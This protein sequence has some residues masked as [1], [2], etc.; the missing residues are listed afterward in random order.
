[1]AFKTFGLLLLQKLAT[2]G[3]APDTR[4]SLLDLCGVWSGQEQSQTTGRDAR[5]ASAI[6]RQ[7]CGLM[8]TAASR[9]K[10]SIGITNK[11]VSMKGGARE[12]FVHPRASCG[13][14]AFLVLTSSPQPP[15]RPLLALSL[16]QAWLLILLRKYT[17]SVGVPC[18]LEMTTFYSLEV[19]CVVLVSPEG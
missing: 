16:V 3:S 7:L 17:G 4:C 1:M 19:T 18:V 11:F 10:D 5:R 6:W 2:T 13:I 12:R 9:K 15:L 8:R 14:Y